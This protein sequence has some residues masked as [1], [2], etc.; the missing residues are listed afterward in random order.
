MAPTVH[1]LGAANMISGPVLSRIGLTNVFLFSF[2]LLVLSYRQSSRWM[3]MA[4]DARQEAQDAAKQAERLAAMGK[5]AAPYLTR[6]TIRSR[7]SLICFTS[8]KR[9]NLRKRAEVI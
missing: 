9:E 3:Q 8:S 2:G 5:I 1:G 4:H 7:R 6:S